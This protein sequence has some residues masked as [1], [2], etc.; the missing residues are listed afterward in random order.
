MGAPSKPR[1]GDPCNRCGECCRDEL[2]PL[3]SLGFRDWRAPCPALIE[4]DGRFVCGLVVAPRRFAPTQ[5]SRH[6]VSRVS[7]AAKT[8]CGIGLG[9]DACADGEF[10]ASVAAAFREKARHI[11]AAIVDRASRVFGI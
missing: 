5:V 7:S 6:G 2:C 8:L 10:D 1:Y 4:Q 11:P 3:A 9:C